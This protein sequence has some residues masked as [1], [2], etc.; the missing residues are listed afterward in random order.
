[1]KNIMKD[2]IKRV[3]KLETQSYIDRAENKVARIEDFM[4]KFNEESLYEFA[5]FIIGL[6]KQNEP[7]E[8]NQVIEG[9]KYIL[10]KQNKNKKK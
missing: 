3:E 10:E 4:E 6:R 5:D 2:I 8:L 7:F 9:A 1:M